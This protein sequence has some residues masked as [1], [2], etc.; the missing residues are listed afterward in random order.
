MRYSLKEEILLRSF[1]FLPAYNRK[2][3]DK[4]VLGDADAIILDMEDSVP[5]EKKNEARKTIIKCHDNGSF[6]NKM[7]FIRINNIGTEDFVRD[8]SELCL[9]DIDGFMP[10][11]ID[12]VEDIVF[13]DKLL[14]FMEIREG[15]ECGHYLLAPLIETTNAIAC[16]EEIAKSSTRLVALCLGGE[17]YLNDLGSV[18]TY[19]ES[20]LVYPRAKLVNAARANGLLPID[21][22]FLN[23]SDLEGLEKAERLA[24]K[25]GFAGSLLV[26]PRQITIANQAFSPDDEKYNISCKILEAC[27]NAYKSG[28]SIVMYDGIMV[29][30]P[31]KKRAETVVKQRK[32]IEK[33]E[34]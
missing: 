7:T 10:S 30:P 25:N 6:K 12:S 5:S 15:I 31:M 9:K 8:I 32:I 29:G 20:A 14:S 22:P 21:T 2:F 27:N 13:M 26:N 1:L 19:Q 34:K 11:K 16:V 18:Y 28:D 33:N 3:I 23:I 24:Y 17:D 4:A